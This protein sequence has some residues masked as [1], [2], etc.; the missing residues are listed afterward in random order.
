MPEVEHGR[1]IV[2]ISAKGEIKQ[3]E[4]RDGE[5][6]LFFSFLA[7]PYRE[8][9]TPSWWPPAD[10]TVSRYVMHGPYSKQQ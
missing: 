1:Q 6:V 10:T 4:D 3:I 5:I 2:E 7:L 9:V 8:S